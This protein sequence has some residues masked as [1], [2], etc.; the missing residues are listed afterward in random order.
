MPCECRDWPSMLWECQG[1]FIEEVMSKLHLE[2]R[3]GVDWLE[4]ERGVVGRGGK[5]VQSQRDMKD[6]NLG[7]G[8]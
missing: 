6:M 7:S 5:N 8:E 2:G 1:N 4:M 3:V